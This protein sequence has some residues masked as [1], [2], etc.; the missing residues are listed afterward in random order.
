MIKEVIK[1]HWEEIKKI[2]IKHLCIAILILIIGIKINEEVSFKIY[3]LTGKYGELPII[4]RDF[5]F[6][7]IPP[8]LV[9]AAWYDIFCL[10][11]QIF[12]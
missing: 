8:N 10:L 1:E 12:L 5:F 7:R 11:A 2:N 6:E 9:Y 4:L 3:Q